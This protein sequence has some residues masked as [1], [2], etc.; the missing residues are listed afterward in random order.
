MY[1]TYPIPRNIN[2]VNQLTND[3]DNPFVDKILKL[4][5]LEVY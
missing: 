5:N 3:Y 1:A 2:G 4:R